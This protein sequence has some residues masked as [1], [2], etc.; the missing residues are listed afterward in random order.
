M[1]AA[2][3]TVW[4]TT[5]SGTATGS[6]SFGYASGYTVQQTSDSGYIVSGAIGN[7]MGGGS[8][9]LLKTSQTGSIQWTASFFGGSLA[10]GVQESSG[11]GYVVSVLGVLP[12]VLVKVDSLG[13]FQWSTSLNGS[14]EA[15]GK[16]SDGG[17]IVTGTTGT[18]DDVYL[19]KVDSAGALLWETSFGSAGGDAGYSVQE[20]ADHGFI[21]A[22]AGSGGGPNHHFDAY[23]VKTDSSGNVQWQ[24]YFGGLGD[25]YG[26]SVSATA[27]GGYIVGGFTNSK[28]A[29][30]DDIYLIKTDSSGNAQW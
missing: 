1:D 13:N 23:L 7:G 24:K 4:T 20:T 26:R 28:G 22:G 6:P 27:D 18:T 15:V 14:A 9:F 19:A 12:P 10:T 3:N 29:G 2:L 11:G 25:D 8:A 21:I 16:T 5:V 30:G 17:Y